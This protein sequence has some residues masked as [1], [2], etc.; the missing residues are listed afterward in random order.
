M[1]FKEALKTIIYYAQGQIDSYAGNYD[2]E[3]Q[4]FEAELEESI[5]VLREVQSLS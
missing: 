2:E 5:K 1:E 3:Y 4:R